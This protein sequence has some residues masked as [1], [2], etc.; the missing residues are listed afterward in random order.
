MVHAKRLRF[1]VILANMHGEYAAFTLTG[2]KDRAR[3]FNA[4]IYIFNADVVADDTVKHTI[5]EYNIYKLANLEQFDGIIFFANLILGHSIHTKIIE[6]IRES[7]KPTVCIDSTIEGFYYVGVEN[8]PAMKAIVDH[9]IEEHHFTKINYISGQDFNSD[10]TERLAA[11]VDSMKEHGL[12]VKDENIFKGAFT[13]VWGMEAVKQMFENDNI[14]E[15]IVCA[16]DWV[17]FGA[18]EELE[19]RGYKVPDDIKI[20]GFDNGFDS[21]NSVPSLTTVD[22]N[23]G[24]VGA[25][26]V[27]TLIKVVTG[28]DVPKS[29]RFPSFPCIRE[30]CG[31]KFSTEDNLEVRLMHLKYKRDITKNL[32][33]LTYMVE[34]LNDASTFEEFMDKLKHSIA[35]LD[36]RNFYLCLDEEL[37][38]DLK[39]VGHDDYVGEFHDSLLLDGIPEKLAVAMAYESGEFKKF[40]S[41]YSK[42]MVPSEASFDDSPHCYVF[43]PIHFRESFMGYTIMDDSEFAIESSIANAWFIYLSISIE[44]LRKQSRLQ[45]ALRKLDSMYVIEPLTKLYNRFGFARFTT[46]SFERC[47]KD[48]KQFMILFADMDG[49]KRIN[50][51]FGHESG[52][53]AIKTLADSLKDAC[54]DREVV[55]RFGG[56]EYVV[57]AEGYTENDALA[58]SA[59]F[60]KS[61]S[62]RNVKIADFDVS[63]SYGY[64]IVSPKEGENLDKYVDMADSI[65][66]EKKKA[67]YNNTEMDRRKN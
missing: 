42:D 54:T 7:G 38:E 65:M 24:L 13:N 4:D 63:A 32:N 66:Y 2:I 59:R 11:Y 64:M 56:D 33:G 22:R 8:Y 62:E 19:R 23:L 61:L 10:S 16:T 39:F 21:R 1:A 12:P 53:I 30:S 46:D 35:E 37:L 34:E 60:L 20:S 9:M 52:D 43:A 45:S 58:F 25:S 18:Q 55:A 48:G 6:K 15:A 41:F 5:G 44:S 50:D 14:P 47:I 17:A 27:E 29:Q 51:K 36:L 3:E 49:L 57:Y 40:G 31:C 26:A 28:E 67:K